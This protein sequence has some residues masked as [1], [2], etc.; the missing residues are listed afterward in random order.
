MQGTLS[1]HGCLGANKTKPAKLENPLK[2]NTQRQEENESCA[3]NT[4]QKSPDQWPC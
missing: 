3:F 2:Q 1:N 4:M